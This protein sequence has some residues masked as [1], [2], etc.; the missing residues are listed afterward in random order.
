MLK[1]KNVEKSYGR[2]SLVSRPSTPIIKGV[3]FECPIGQTVAIIGESGSGKSTLS[4]MILGIEKPD[5][6]QVTLFNQPVH[7]KKV[8]RHQ[9]AA[10]FRLYIV[11]S[12]LSHSQRNNV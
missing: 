4:R 5:K 3:S 10:V 2:K 12:S 7:I 9:I 6:G 1:I 8:R 11:A